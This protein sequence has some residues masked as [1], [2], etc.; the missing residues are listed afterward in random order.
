MWLDDSAF[1]ISKLI[2]IGLNPLRCK[3]SLEMNTERYWIG[4]IKVYHKEMIWLKAGDIEEIK[5]SLILKKCFSSP[6][7]FF[8][9][10]KESPRTFDTLLV[11]KGTMSLRFLFH[12]IK[13]L[14]P[15]NTENT[16]TK[17]CLPPNP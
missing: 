2:L 15:L 16:V 5:W 9:M 8:F 3:T 6:K 11:L 1:L 13:D 12:Y 4:D 17:L 14:E 7:I 10:I